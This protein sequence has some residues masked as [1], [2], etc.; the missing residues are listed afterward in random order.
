MDGIAV[1][2]VTD[3]PETDKHEQKNFSLQTEHLIPTA[4]KDHPYTHAKG[5]RRSVVGVYMQ[6]CRRARGILLL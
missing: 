4:P 5:V 1:R 6:E 2:F 3:N